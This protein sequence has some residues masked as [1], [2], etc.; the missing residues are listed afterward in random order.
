MTTAQPGRSRPSQPQHLK[1]YN[2]L[3]AEDDMLTADSIRRFLEE[4]NINVTHARDGDE[5]LRLYGTQPYDLVISDFEMPKKN[6][7]ELLQHIKGTTPSQKI[8]FLTA[9]SQ[10]EILFNALDSGAAAYYLKPID[11]KRLMNEIMTL[12]E[13]KTEG[14]VSRAHYPLRIQTGSVRLQHTAIEFSGCP[15][16]VRLIDLIIGRLPSRDYD[17]IIV[18]LRFDEKFG[19]HK[20]SLQMIANLVDDLINLL[21]IEPSDI[22]LSGE[23]FAKPGLHRADAPGKLPRCRMLHAAYN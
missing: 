6:G 21:H 15:G 12:L 16:N 18:S 8:I 5:A 7:L 23:Y 22:D 14:L 11:L 17:R 2:I 3:L 13:V 10:K 20:D 9:F 19:L 1:N 4:F